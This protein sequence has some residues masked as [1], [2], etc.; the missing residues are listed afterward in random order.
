MKICLRISMIIIGIILS[1]F[2]PGITN[3]QSRGIWII[4]LEIK[5]WFLIIDW[6]GSINIW[7]ISS[8]P[9]PEERTIPIDN[10]LHI[11]D[12][13]WLCG[14]YYTTIQSSN[15]SF[16]THTISNIRAN[17]ASINTIAGKVNNAL[18]IGTAIDNKQGNIKIPKTYIQRPSGE[19]CLKIGQYTSDWNIHITVPANQT[20]GNYRWKLYYLLIDNN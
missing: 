15:L 11:R 2:S 17:I 5:R 7:A 4:S 9:T 10:T 8:V 1:S 16:A 18:S 6:S 13:S 20:A 19:D 12:T 14:N 3:A